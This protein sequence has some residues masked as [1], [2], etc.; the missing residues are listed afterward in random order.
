MCMN[1][2]V[3]FNP[4]D[5][6]ARC[7][8]LTS[9][10]L[11]PTLSF[12]AEL[13][14]DFPINLQ[15]GHVISQNQVEKLYI[16]QYIYLFSIFY[17]RKKMFA[18]VWVGSVKSSSDGFPMEATFRN[19]SQIKWQDSLGKLILWICENVPHGVLC[20]LPSYRLMEILRER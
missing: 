6:I 17:S 18:K 15:T 19:T 12:P 13:G 4:I 3:V 10:T 16:N 9:G 8:I 2:A 20:F 7:I 11:T 14:S 5:K 1:P